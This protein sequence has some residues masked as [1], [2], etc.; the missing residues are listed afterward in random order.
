MKINVI[1]Y[2][3]KSYIIKV[4]MVLMV[5]FFTLGCASQRRNAKHKAVPCP[6]S[7]RR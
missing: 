7:Q 3:L 4:L 2:P 1:R 6:C 5:V